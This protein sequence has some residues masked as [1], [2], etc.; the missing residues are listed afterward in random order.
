MLLSIAALLVELTFSFRIRQKAKTSAAMNSSEYWAGVAMDSRGSLQAHLR[1]GA[2][3]VSYR[4]LWNFYT[5]EWVDLPG[6]CTGKVY[7]IYSARCWTPGTDQCGN[8]RGEGDCYNREHSWPKSWWGGSS[9]TPA[10]SDLFHVMPSDGFVNG[11]RANF[12]FGEVSR[13]TYTSSEGHKLGPCTTPGFSGTCF[14]PVNRIKGAMARGYLDMTVRYM[15]ELSCCSKE[16]VDGADLRAWT[17]TLMLK[18]NA[19][20]FPSKWE[21]EFNNRAYRWQGNRNPFID[22]PM[23]ARRVFP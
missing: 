11:R 3:V 17:M 16:Q 4:N 8:Y 20:F 19:A 18:W 14:E 5:S 1:Q 6:G 12:P 23:L 15:D 2:K 9:Q 22:D 13:P 7:D 10:Y 21:K